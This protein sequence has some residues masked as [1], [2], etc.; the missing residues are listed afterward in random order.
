MAVSYT[1]KG[2]SF[3]SAKPRVWSD[4]QIRPADVGFPA[5]DI[6]PDGKHFAILPW[7]DPISA[8]GA[9][10]HATFLVNFFDE[11]RRRVPIGK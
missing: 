3:L 5:L 8:Q 9:S 4:T 2:D 1:V 6:A 11:L 10:L 7:N